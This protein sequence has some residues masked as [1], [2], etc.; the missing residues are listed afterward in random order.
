VSLNL[1]QQLSSQLQVLLGVEN[2]TNQRVIYTDPL[3]P[4]RQS[5]FQFGRRFNVG[6]SH[7]I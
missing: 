2:L 7:K 4:Y 6:V 1:A 3:N 5:N